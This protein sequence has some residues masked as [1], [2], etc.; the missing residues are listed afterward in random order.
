MKKRFLLLCFLS[1]RFIGFNQLGT[2]DPNFNVVTGFGPDE[3]TGRGEIIVQQ[4]DGKLLVGGTFTEYNG[5]QAKRLVRIN[6]D[7]SIDNS[8][9]IG[10]GF[11]GVS[12]Y[13]K[14]IAVQPDGKILVGGN[15]LEFNGTTRHRIVRLN[16]NGTLDVSF[17]PNSGFDS[18][19]N[20]IAI[21]SDGKII[22]GG[23][24]AAYDWLNS[25][26]VERQ[27][28]ARLNSDGSLDMSFVPKVFTTTFGQIP[29]HQ[30]IVQPDGKILVG[31]R[32]ISY[33]EKQR[34]NVLRLNTDATLDTS[35]GSDD[36]TDFQANDFT[37]LYGEVFKM[38]LLSNGKVVIGGNFEFQHTA[39]RSGLARLNADGSKDETMEMTEWLNVEA[40][41]V[42]ADGKIFLSTAGFTRARRYLENGMMDPAFPEVTINNAARSIIIQDD[43]NITMVGYFSY[44]PQGIMR[45]IGDTPNNTTSN[46]EINLNALNVY[47]NP[48][49]DFIFVK[50]IPINSSV[51]LVDLSGK[52][53]V[54]TNAQVDILKMDCQHLKSGS[55]FLEINSEAGTKVLKIVV[56]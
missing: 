31:G 11:T 10:D 1:I 28:I 18:D 40:M 9:Q 53:H 7:G 15:F 22:V 56:L 49:Q 34:I 38:A 6:L 48:T 24:F 8:F 17:N 36:E 51:K 33:D 29:I 55:Y 26:G 45:L 50:N 39:T 23:L 21:Q 4:P 3:W 30:V 19:V 2:I 14:A 47:P 42:Q 13:V 16:S 35:F 43:G 25:G 20:T 5:S 44:N 41:A 12:P 54:H 32:F 46:I 37:G 27:R 52:V